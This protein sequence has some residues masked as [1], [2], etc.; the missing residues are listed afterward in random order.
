MM[1]PYT[2]D[3]SLP[4]AWSNLHPMPKIIKEAGPV[5]LATGELVQSFVIMTSLS[6]QKHHLLWSNLHPAEDQYT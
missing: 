2:D 5:M 3:S 4:S 6:L 1:A